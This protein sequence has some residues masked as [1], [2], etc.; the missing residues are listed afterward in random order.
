MNLS[1]LAVF[2][3]LSVS[4]AVRYTTY[5]PIVEQLYFTGNDIRKNPT[6][7]KD[8]VGGEEQKYVASR[9]KSK[10]LEW[11]DGLARSCR[12]LVLDIGPFGLE[13]H[14]TSTG[15]D[16]RARAAIYT[17][18]VSFLQ[19]TLVYN[20]IDDV[21]KSER[22]AMDVY[23]LMM[24]NTKERDNLFNGA[25]THV[26]ISCGCHASRVEVCCFAYGK[27]VIN[28]RGV[29]SMDVAMINPKTCDDSAKLSENLKVGANSKV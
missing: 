26:G 2:V 15:K 28:K 6:L 10:N 11:S 22:E 17:S 20:E 3:I 29:E 21:A 16:E 1:I 12:D 23:E 4:Y 8:R 27:D 25:F 9:D 5:E 24:K 14:S 13:G 18:S 19:E 7:L